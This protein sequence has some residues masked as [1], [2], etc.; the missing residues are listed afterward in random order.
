[1]HISVTGPLCCS[2]AVHAQACLQ[3]GQA[4]SQPCP[5]VPAAPAGAC[6][7]AACCS[8]AVG[9]TAPH[10]ARPDR[11]LLRRGS[12]RG[13]CS[14]QRAQ[15]WPAVHFCRQPM[16]SSGGLVTSGAGPAQTRDSQRA[17]TACSRPGLHPPSRARQEFIPK[18]RLSCAGTVGGRPPSSCSERCRAM[19]L[20]GA[21][22]LPTRRWPPP[23]ADTP[24]RRPTPREHAPCRLQCAA[25][26]ATGAP[27]AAQ[28]STGVPLRVRA[29]ARRGSGRCRCIGVSVW[30]W[31]EL[32][33]T[34]QVLPLRLTSRLASAGGI[35]R[36][37]QAEPT[38]CCAGSRPGRARVPGHSAFASLRAAGDP[39]QS[40]GCNRPDHCRCVAAAGQG[41]HLP[42]QSPVH[43]ASPCSLPE[44]AAGAQA[45]GNTW[46]LPSASM[47]HGRQAEG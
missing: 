33:L 8:G 18:V 29:A 41:L 4:P 1:M 11:L 22:Q 38:C 17:L 39:L 10:R 13:H 24:R 2:C 21:S 9:R 46:R 43:S 42:M 28:T 7:A 35:A 32:L 27:W 12:C 26:P 40:L 47:P 44:M 5:P 31:L 25:L 37:S 19:S 23:E 45:R 6:A 36:W 15:G 20:G 3:L 16:G 30:S 14:P 34:L